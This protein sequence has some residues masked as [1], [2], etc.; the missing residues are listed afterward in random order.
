EYSPGLLVLRLEET[1]I[2]AAIGIVVALIFLPLSAHDTVH[3][4]RSALLTRLSEVLNAIA[5]RMGEPGAQAG[6]GSDKPGRAAVL[7]GSAGRGER[8]TSEG[9]AVP[10]GGDDVISDADP[11]PQLE[12]LVREL[13]DDVRQ[14]A[15]VATPFSRPAMW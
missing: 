13:D 1:A 6:T 12:Q 5:D 7:A 11:P 15:L 8:L 9:D 3:S 4:A 10:R 14:L 2:G